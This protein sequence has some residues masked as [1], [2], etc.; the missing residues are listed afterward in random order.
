VAG[1]FYCFIER[2]LGNPVITGKSYQLLGQF[3]GQDWN[4]QK[5]PGFR[6]SLAERVGFEST[7]RLPAQRFSSSK[8]LVLACAAQ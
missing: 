5:I 3:V 7:V 1:A 8:I 6:V 2:S 4:A